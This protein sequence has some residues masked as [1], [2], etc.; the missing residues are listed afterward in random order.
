[1]LQKPDFGYLLVLS[2]FLPHYD[3]IDFCGPR[4]VYVDQ[5]GPSGFLSCAGLVYS[6]LADAA[7]RCTKLHFLAGFDGTSNVLAGK[8]YGIPI[9]GT[10]AHSFVNSF[11]S[12]DE[13]PNSVRNALWFMPFV[14]LSAGADAPAVFL[15]VF[16]DSILDVNASIA[17]DGLGL[18]IVV[19]CCRVLRHV[20]RLRS[21][22]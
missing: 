20:F 14:E 4:R 11:K 3:E 13:L 5:F 18:S 6:N 15:L 8:M 1:M 7:W 16:I 19:T 12:F 2:E 21:G 17:V 22:F 10:H 9:S